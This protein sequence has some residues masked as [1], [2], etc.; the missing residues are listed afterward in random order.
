MAEY[1]ADA[2]FDRVQARIIRMI[3]QKQEET[4]MATYPVCD[5]HKARLAERLGNKIR[6]LETD[7]TPSLGHYTLCEAHHL[8]GQNGQPLCKNPATH[9]YALDM[10]IETM[11]GIT[12]VVD[13]WDCEC[14]QD[15]IHAKLDGDVEQ[16][17]NR[18]GSDMDDCPNSRL[19]EVLFSGSQ[20][21]D[22]N[23]EGEVKDG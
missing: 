3:K 13:Y 7:N 16:F 20:I 15:Y 21:M 2:E 17:C 5:T 22:S 9:R 14:E 19:D 11:G 4:K 1:N 8:T 6:F 10:Q 12:T 23:K 18:C